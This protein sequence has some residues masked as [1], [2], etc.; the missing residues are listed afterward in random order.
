MSGFK[1]LK[2][3]PAIDRGPEGKDL[4]HISKRSR[5][6][7]LTWHCPPVYRAIFSKLLKPGFM[8]TYMG[9][10]YLLIPM[11]GYW[12]H[13][14]S[15][16]SL[17][18]MSQKG[19]ME[20][21]T[22]NYC[23]ALAPYIACLRSECTSVANV[24]PSVCM[25]RERLEPM[26]SGDFI[27]YKRIGKVING[28]VVHVPGISIS[29]F[30]I[31]PLWTNIYATSVDVSKP[32]VIV[33]AMNNILC[34][35]QLELLL[36]FIG[37]ALL[38]PVK[39]HKVLYLYG[40]AG[41][42]GK[43][44]LIS[45]VTR[46]L[47]GCV[48]ALPRDYISGLYKKID[49]D[50]VHVLVN[51]RILTWG[52]VVLKQGKVNESF[53]KMIGSN[54]RVSTNGVDLTISSSVL[55]ASNHMWYPNKGCSRE[56]FTRRTL[57]II[58]ENPLLEYP[59]IPV[60]LTDAHRIRFVSHCLKVRLANEHPPVGVV[61]CMYIILGSRSSPALRGIILNEDANVV[62]RLTALVSISVSSQVPVD[63]ILRLVVS[64]NPSLL[65]DEM[66]VN[67]IVDISYFTEDVH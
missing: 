55:A 14:A 21:V 44:S 4:F 30:C 1:Y 3:A 32:G 51:N 2:N 13:C 47:L 59:Y 23:K 27:Q 41:G 6:T 64:V 16:E 11:V 42:E 66:G 33:K 40:R 31:R 24:I 60:E 48:S 50:D 8:S 18:V 22:V 9:D 20:N 12:M 67:T 38:D 49:V 45:I 37:N 63:D 25:G 43:S 10:L 65:I 17:I 36:W 39:K 56:W 58:M 15:N 28:N 53:Y 29:A 52:D 19:G 35:S 5:D 54:D 26:L 61:A 34:D 46:A 62:E 57:A 7:A